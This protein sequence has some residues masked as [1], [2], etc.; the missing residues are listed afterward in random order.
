MKVQKNFKVP[1]NYRITDKNLYYFGNLEKKTGKYINNSYFLLMVKIGFAGL[2]TNSL[3]GTLR[4][5]I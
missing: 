3:G 5:N 2:F 4:W 1:I